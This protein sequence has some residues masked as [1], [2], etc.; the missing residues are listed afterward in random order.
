MKT[1]F[2]ASAAALLA[3]VPA[4]A[5]TAAGSWTGPYVG[6]QVGIGLLDSDKARIEFDTNRDGSFGDTVRTAAGADAFS[7]GFCS[8]S[9]N[10]DRQTGGCDSVQDGVEYG[11]HLG[12]DFDVGGLVVGLVGE[13]DRH[14]VE[15][16]VAAFSTTPASY[17]MTRELK[18]SYGIRA[19]AGVPVGPNTLAY[20]T[21]GA[22]NGRFRHSF[23]STNTLNAF[24]VTD[25][26]SNNWGY[27]V[28]GG[29]EHR[30]TPNFSFGG[31]YLFTSIKDDE[32][33]RIDVTRGSAGATNPF[34]LVNSAGTQFR[35]TDE[36]FRL[37]SLKLTGSFRF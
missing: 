20:A 33:S 34:I 28:G 4:Q 8:G 17:T 2:L 6:G 10:S 15:D 3:A 37:H 22:V 18:S 32:D 14:E 21:G 11:A 26:K 30:L 7:P 19:R 12:Y 9:A 24:E 23:E 5:Q 27:R 16:S 31:L 36:R 1:I 25:R 35:R 29:F 13:Y